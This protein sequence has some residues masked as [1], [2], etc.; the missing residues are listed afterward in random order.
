MY[1]VDIEYPKHLHDDH[2]DLPFLPNKSIPRGSKIPKLTATLES[3]EHYIIHYRNL[4]QAMANGL[5]VKKVHRVLQFIQSP[6]LAKYINLNT[7]MRKKARNDFEKDFYKL[8]NNSVFGMMMSRLLNGQIKE[9][10]HFNIISALQQQQQQPQQLTTK[11]LPQEYDIKHSK[12]KSMLE[13]IAD[14]SITTDMWTSDSNKS[15]ITVTCHF[16]F[17]NHLY[18]P[19]LTTREVFD[20]HTGLNIATTLKNIFNEWGITNKIV[21]IVSDNGSNI[22]NAINEHLVKYHHPCVAHTLNLSINEAINGNLDIIQILK[23]CRT[24]VSHF[25]HSSYANGKLRE[26]Q[27]QMNLPILKVKQDIVIRWNSSLIMIK[28]LNDIKNPL[29]ATMSSLP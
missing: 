5:K 4:K 6:W 20:N 26:F 17:D 18:S 15:Y 10:M 1:E 8:M 28:R 19:V 22:K 29:S 11:L 13:T 24:I 9:C 27:L 14:L 16:I 3:K 7:E 23:K 25:K 2:N 21:T 12:L